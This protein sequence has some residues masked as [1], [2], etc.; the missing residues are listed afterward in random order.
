[1]KDGEVVKMDTYIKPFTEMK[2]YFA[3]A[4]FNLDSRREN[5]E[6]LLEA[7]SVDREDGEIER[8]AIK[9][10]IK[11]IKEVSVKLPPSKGDMQT[12]IDNEQPIYCYILCDRQKK[13]Q[14]LLEDCT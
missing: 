1:M 4:K 10:Y 9:I 8:A 7:D 12:N 11:R 13:G 14:P 3:D 6:E 2:S 5:M